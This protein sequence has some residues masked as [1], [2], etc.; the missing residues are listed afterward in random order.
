VRLLQD[1][2]K[3]RDTNVRAWFALGMALQVTQQNNQAIAAY[4]KYL[5]MDP[6]GTF[7]SDVRLAL[8]QLGSK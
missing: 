3:E 8:K 2:V 6:S 7:S 1:V 5:A 4:K